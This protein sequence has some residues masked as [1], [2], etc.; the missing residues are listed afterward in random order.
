MIDSS[1]CM[2]ET[3][4]HGKEI[5]FQLKRSMQNQNI[6]ENFT[7]RYGMSTDHQYFKCS[8]SNMTNEFP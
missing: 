8:V 3:N 7:K 6:E 5:I 2:A 1:C 4:T